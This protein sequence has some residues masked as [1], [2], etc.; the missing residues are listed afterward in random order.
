MKFC[1]IE[2]VKGINSVNDSIKRDEIK[3][4][5]AK[6]YNISIDELNRW[7]ADGS[8]SVSSDP[9]KS[10]LGFFESSKGKNNKA[11]NRIKRKCRNLI[12]DSLFNSKI[13]AVDNRELNSKLKSLISAKKTFRNYSEPYKGIKDA[14]EIHKMGDNAFKEENDQ[15]IIDYLLI[16]HMDLVVGA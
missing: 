13:P 5:I 16:N 6:E 9:R 11:Y 1:Q 7:I 3:A 10:I 8:N 4:E 2:I 15:F 12:I 14:I